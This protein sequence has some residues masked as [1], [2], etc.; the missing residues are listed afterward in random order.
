[1]GCGT[2]SD[3]RVWNS[4]GV[5]PSAFGSGAGRRA[6]VEQKARERAELQAKIQTLN[7][8]REKHIANRRKAAPAADT[9]DA[10]VTAAVREQ[11]VRRQFRFE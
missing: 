1:M 10:V 4:F 11:A 3:F 5:R 6:F 8:E 2:G 9:L 7:R